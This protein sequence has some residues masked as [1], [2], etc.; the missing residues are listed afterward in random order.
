MPPLL[1][2]ADATHPFLLSHGQG[3]SGA[4]L[5]AASSPK[6]TGRATREL[7][8]PPEANPFEGEAG[9]GYG[10]VLAQI[11]GAPIP[12]SYDKAAVSREVKW[13]HRRIPASIRVRVSIRVTSLDPGLN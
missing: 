6:V 5:A 3:Y 9:D 8:P 7:A 1:R 11:Y 13:I 10:A 12:P 4:P 2:K